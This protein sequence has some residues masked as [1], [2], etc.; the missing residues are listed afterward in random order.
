MEEGSTQPWNPDIKKS[1]SLE[2]GSPPSSPTS[3]PFPAPPAFGDDDQTQVYTP[4]FGSQEDKGKE[5]EGKE[6]NQTGGHGRR[7]RLN[8]LLDEEEEEEEEKKEEVKSKRRRGKREMASYGG[9]VSRSN[10]FFFL[11]F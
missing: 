1:K 5:K 6:E 10:G 9:P 3:S 4:T 8:S 7:G 11:S 2:M